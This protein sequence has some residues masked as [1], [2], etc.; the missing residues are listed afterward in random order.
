MSDVLDI[1]QYLRPDP[2]RSDQHL[3]VAQRYAVAALLGYCEAIIS[4]GGLS[5]THEMELRLRV[6]TTCTVFG[7]PTKAERV[8]T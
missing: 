8:P 5:E 3:S 2:R 1:K 7:L 6:N 4:V